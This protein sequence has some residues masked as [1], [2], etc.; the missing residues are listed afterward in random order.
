MTVSD[1]QNSLRTIAFNMADLERELYDKSVRLDLACRPSINVWN[2]MRSVQLKI[3]E[4]TVHRGDRHDITVAS[5]EILE[6][7]QLKIVDRRGIPDKKN[8]LR[9]LLGM[10]QKTLMYVRDDAAVDQLRRIV[11]R[12]ASRTRLGLCCSATPEAERDKMKSALIQDELDAIASS[13]PFEEPLS[14]LKHL[15]FCH[16]VPTRSYFARCCAPAVEA[17]ELVYVHLIFNTKDVDWLTA[18]LNYQYPD[19]QTL[20]NVYRKLSELS[21]DRD[22]GPVPIEEIAESMDMDGPKELIVSNC[23]AIF[24]EIDLAERQQSNEKVAVSLPPAPQEKRDL[25]ESQCY[26]DGN[27]IRSEWTEFSDLILKRTAEDIH[28]MLLETIT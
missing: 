24:Q 11:S 8:H 27:R 9:K 20:V 23:V 15:V 5:A 3:E 28:R 17:E 6:L 19:R 22:G 16:P 14:G 13:V 12:Y 7:S 10:R 1:G 18:T 21:K 26:A 25:Q 2:D 4:I